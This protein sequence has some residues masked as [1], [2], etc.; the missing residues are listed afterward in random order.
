[1]D[2]TDTLARLTGLTPADV[3]ELAL[4]LLFLAPALGFIEAWLGSRLPDWRAEARATR[5]LADDRGVRFVGWVHTFLVWVATAVAWILPRV[6][7]GIEAARQAGRGPSS[8]SG[9]GGTRYYEPEGP[10]TRNMRAAPRRPEYGPGIRTDSRV[11]MPPVFAAV[12]LLLV[13]F[14]LPGCGASTSQRMHRG[15]NTATDYVD[16]TYE[17]AVIECDAQ[18]EDVIARHSPDERAAAAEALAIV[19]ERCDVV[20]ASFEELRTM[21]D[22]LRATADAAEDGRA[23]KQDVIRSLD[24]VMEQARATRELVDALRAVRAGGR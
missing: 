23:T 3:G 13:A 24:E 18:E 16:P 15:L 19:R 1:M 14:A 11:G 7:K 9:G 4:W 17:A 21:Q 12:S 8:G 22:T 5:T 6:G 10:D 2:L 20:F